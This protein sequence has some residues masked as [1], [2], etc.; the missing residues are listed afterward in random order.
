MSSSV[1]VQWFL[2]FFCWRTAPRSQTDHTRILHFPPANTV[3]KSGSHR[4]PGSRCQTPNK[5][6]FSDDQCCSALL[7]IRQR[8][9]EQMLSTCTY[10]MQNCWDWIQWV[11]WLGKV[12]LDGL[13]MFNV[14]YKDDTDWSNTVHTVMHVQKV[15]HESDGMP[16]EDWLFASSCV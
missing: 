11:W 13:D 5:K 1:L 6:L 15:R 9:S 7:S 16:D 3:R 12:D 8:L 10:C 4:Q 2:A 14:K